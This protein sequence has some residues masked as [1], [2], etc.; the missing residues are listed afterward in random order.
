VNEVIDLFQ[1]TKGRWRWRFRSDDVALDSNESYGSAHE[2]R[3]AA[4]IA[5]PGVPISGHDVT[6]EESEPSSA[7]GWVAL[8]LVIAVLLRAR[9]SR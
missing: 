1:G 2:A 3:D 9:K 5:F 4:L 7:L 6:T 8:L